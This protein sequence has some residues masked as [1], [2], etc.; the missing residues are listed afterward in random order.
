MSLFPHSTEIVVGSGFKNPPKVL[1]GYPKKPN[2]PVLAS[3]FEGRHL[4]EINFTKSD[5]EIGGFAAHDF[6]GDGSFYLL[7]K[8][9][10]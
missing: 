6:F 5:S 10:P 2:S 8:Y 9:N 1:P 4:N 3:D 7:G